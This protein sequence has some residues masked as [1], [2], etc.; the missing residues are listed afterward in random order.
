MPGNGKTERTLKAFEFLK[1]RAQ[2]Q[3]IFTV[4]ALSKASGWSEVSVRTY[5]GKT[6]GQV[7]ERLPNDQLRAKREILD[8]NANRPH[9]ALCDM[10]PNEFAAKQRPSGA[11]HQ[12]RIGP[13]HGEASPPSRIKPR[14][15]R[16]SIGRVRLWTSTGH[17]SW[18]TPRSST[19]C[20][21]GCSSAPIPRDDSRSP[22]RTFLR[23]ARSRPG[24]EC[25]SP[26]TM[27]ILLDEFGGPCG[28][29]RPHE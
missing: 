16:S 18:R 17:G 7:V 3:K 25:R 27:D 24:S 2:D 6:L 1:S 23:G 9:T 10:T 5:V 11:D 28:S 29:P 26:W 13:A 14:R 21:S 4:Q 22:G 19:R 20:G 8:Y 15:C 12:P